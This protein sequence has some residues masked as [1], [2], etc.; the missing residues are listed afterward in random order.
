[1]LTRATSPIGLT[2]MQDAELRPLE[3][4][5][6]DTGRFDLTAGELLRLLDP[7]LSPDPAR[8]TG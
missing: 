8:R 1:V 2:A 5:L 3:R 4:Q 7:L 6:L